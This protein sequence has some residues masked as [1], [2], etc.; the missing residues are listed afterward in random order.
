M[1]AALV[2]AVKRGVDVQVMVPGRH[3]DMPWSARRHRQ[4]YGELLRRGV[5]ICE[6]EPHML[7]NKTMVVDGI[8]STIGTINFDERSISK[9]AEDSLSVYD[10]DFGREMEVTFEKDR[11]RCEE[12]HHERW[13]KRGLTND[14]RSSSSSGS[15]RI[16]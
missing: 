8:F 2:D 4:D 14:S 13:K 15:R 7:H 12:D 6:Y 16:Y 9:N 5:R 3:I 11:A 10:R 1:R